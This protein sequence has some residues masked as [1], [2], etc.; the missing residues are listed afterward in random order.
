MTVEGFCS[1]ETNSTEDMNSTQSLGGRGEDDEAITLPDSI[2]ALLDGARQ[3]SH[4]QLLLQEG[5]ANRPETS[6]SSL[7]EIVRHDQSYPV[8]VP[9]SKAVRQLDSHHPTNTDDAMRA[10]CSSLPNTGLRDNNR[11]SQLVS[12]FFAR[13]KSGGCNYQNGTFEDKSDFC[14]KPLPTVSRDESTVVHKPQPHDDDC[15]YYSAVEEAPGKSSIKN[16]PEEKLSA[17]LMKYQYPKNSPTSADTTTTTT[18][19]NE[20]AKAQA[21]SSSNLF[22]RMSRQMKTG[23]RGSVP[24]PHRRNRIKLHVYDLIPSETVMQLPWG[25]MFPIGVCFDAVNSGLHS[26]G[27]G[28]YHV[29]IEVNGVEYSFG[30]CDIPGHTGVFSCIPKRSPGYQ[31]RTTVDFGERSLVT[32]KTQL[33]RAGSENQLSEECQID[34]RELIKQMATEYMGTDYDLLR[35]NCVTFASDAAIRLG[36]EEQE[37]PS[38]FRNLCESGAL[39]Q[40]VALQTVE[41]IQ[42]MLSSCEDYGSL[43]GKT[44]EDGFEIITKTDDGSGKGVM[45]VDP[46]ESNNLAQCADCAPL[47]GVRQTLSWAY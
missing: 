38:W 45:V 9:M 11:D 34:G 14:E 42:F 3:S 6:L 2:R 39:T 1:F 15:T 22:L 47:G 16:G 31:F 28:A 23:R 32:R 27:T 13:K 21:R 8:S 17:V 25:C 19:R 12:P 10:S 30:A 29:G 41:P 37:I 26:M 5:K 43:A 36:I 44:I 33:K 4:Q 35:K 24:N 7:D 46:D 40:D 18:C 20:T